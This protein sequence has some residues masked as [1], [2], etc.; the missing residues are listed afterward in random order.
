MVDEC[1]WDEYEKMFWCSISPEYYANPS[2]QD[3]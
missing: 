1:E 2:F 3:R